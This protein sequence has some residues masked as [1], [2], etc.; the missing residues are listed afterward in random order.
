M[1]P[2]LISQ[3]GE[4]HLVS[5]SGRYGYLRRFCGEKS[6]QHL[7]SQILEATKETK[8]A[9]H[10]ANTDKHT[11]FRSSKGSFSLES[12]RVQPVYNTSIGKYSTRLH[13]L[14]QNM[15]DASYPGANLIVK[16]S[17]GPQGNLADMCFLPRYFC[18]HAEKSHA[19]RLELVKLCTTRQ[20]EVQGECSKHCNN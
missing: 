9:F 19:L 5:P 2:H 11:R 8:R 7:E 17:I 16:I 1:E 12:S 4:R 13:K 15:Y 6:T 20:S 10:L 18:W 14:W 3:A